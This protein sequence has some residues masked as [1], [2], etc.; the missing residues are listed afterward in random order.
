MNN[1]KDHRRRGEAFEDNKQ[2]KKISTMTIW[3]LMQV[4]FEDDTLRIFA[5]LGLVSLVLEIATE[6]EVG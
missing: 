1:E 2:R 5:F 6:T 4:N 3:E